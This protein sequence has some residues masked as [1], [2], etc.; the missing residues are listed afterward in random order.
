[1][2]NNAY[3]QYHKRTLEYVYDLERSGFNTYL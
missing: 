1:M 2:V 3:W